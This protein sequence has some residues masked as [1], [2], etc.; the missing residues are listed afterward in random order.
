MAE[1]DKAGDEGKRCF[2]LHLHRAR[3]YELCE[4]QKLGIGGLCQGDGTYQTNWNGLPVIPLGT[5]DLAGQFHLIA[6][7]VVHME[8]ELVYKDCWKGMISI[9][10][11]ILHKDHKAIFEDFDVGSAPEY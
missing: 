7:V 2:H 5:T 3:G 6:H 1:S 4:A 11:H 10:P 8:N 9:A